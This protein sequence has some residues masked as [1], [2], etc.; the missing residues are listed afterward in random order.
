MFKKIIFVCVLSFFIFFLLP[1][2]SFAQEKID[3][4]MFYGQGCPHC[5]KLEMFLDEIAEK[6][7]QLNIQKHEIYHDNENRELFQKMAEQYNT[8]IGGVPTVFINN[9]VIVGFSNTIATDIENM[10]SKNVENILKR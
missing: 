8:T 4:H 2:N 5:A 9:S 3:L 10:L 6:Y 1:V 7:P